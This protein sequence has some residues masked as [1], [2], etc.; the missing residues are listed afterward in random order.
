[1]KRM[2]VMATLISA[3][4]LVP[5]GALA[6]S[7]MLAHAMQAKHQVHPNGCSS[8][9]IFKQ[10]LNL[11]HETIYAALFERES[12]SPCAPNGNYFAQAQVDFSG[13]Q[14]RSGTLYAELLAGPPYLPIETATLT[15][16]PSS[17][18]VDTPATSSFSACGLKAFALFDQNGIGFMSTQAVGFC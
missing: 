9:Q 17:H 10:P 11:T 1:M 15:Y 5:V 12:G 16:S 18:I 2:V 6:H 13:T 7:G 8:L 4:M 14:S 3:L